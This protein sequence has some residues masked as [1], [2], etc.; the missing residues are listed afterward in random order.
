M[1]SPPLPHNSAGRYK[2]HLKVELALSLN[3][4][5]VFRRLLVGQGVRG[6]L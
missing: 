4:K 2:G 5:G 3:N 6:E 1:A